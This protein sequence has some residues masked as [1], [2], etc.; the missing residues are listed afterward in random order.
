MIF[1]Q[2]TSWELGLLL[3]AVIIGATGLVKVD[4]P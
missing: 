2:L 4:S 3:F 1:F